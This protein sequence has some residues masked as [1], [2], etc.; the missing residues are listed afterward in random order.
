M[1]EAGPFPGM[2]PQHAEASVLRIDR[3]HCQLDSTGHIGV[4]P[5][6]AEFISGT[7]RLDVEG[8]TFSSFLR[9]E[10]AATLDL[11]LARGCSLESLLTFPGHWEGRWLDLSVAPFL[12]SDGKVLGYTVWMQAMV[13]QVAPAPDRVDLSDATSWGGQST[14]LTADLLGEDGYGMPLNC[15]GVLRRGVFTQQDAFLQK[16]F[17]P[18]SL[19]RRIQELI[20]ISTS[21]MTQSK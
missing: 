10:S 19:V 6:E 7:S 11:F 3:A 5:P 16:P 9:G 1:T 2:R 4:W 17:T 12:A 14:S 21:S 15:A 8:K 18:S 13:E 20:Q